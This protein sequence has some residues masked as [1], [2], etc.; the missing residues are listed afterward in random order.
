MINWL[1]EP[2]TLPFVQKGVVDV[3]VLSVAAGILGTWI[4]LRGLSFYS[5]AV[6]PAAFPGV[7]LVGGLGFPPAL[8]AFGAALLMTTLFIVPAATAR[9]WAKRFLPWQVYSVILVCAESVVGLWLSVKFNTPGA[10]IAIVAGCTFALAALLSSGRA[11]VMNRT[12]RR[13]LGEVS[14]RG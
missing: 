11:G 8:G 4:V 10:T 12:A 3:L 1:I 6:G 2:F 14:A 7:V 9:L 5:H 13:R